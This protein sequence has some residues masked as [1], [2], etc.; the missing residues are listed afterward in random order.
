MIKRPTPGTF[1]SQI[2][3][4]AFGHLAA[5]LAT[6]DILFLHLHALFC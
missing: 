1:D 3:V 5:A 4:L 6:P 2:N